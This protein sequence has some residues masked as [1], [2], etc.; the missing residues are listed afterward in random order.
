MSGRSCWIGVVVLAM[1]AVGLGA[2]APVRAEP[3]CKAWRFPAGYAELV[4]D[5]GGKLTIHPFED[6]LGGDA[7]EIAGDGSVRG[8]RLSGYTQDDRLHMRMEYF[9]M[10]MHMPSFRLVEGYLDGGVDAGGF[11]YGTRIVRDIEPGT[12]AFGPIWPEQTRSWRSSTPLKCAPETPPVPS[13]DVLHPEQGPPLDLGPPSIVDVL[14]PGVVPVWEPGNAPSVA[15]VMTPG[16][17]PVWEPG[18]PE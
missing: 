10:W 13:G 12:T 15:D 1:C 4:Y 3:P 2:V 17:V 18:D 8:G 9:D 16:V 7:Q 6:S 11:A 5:D 14:T